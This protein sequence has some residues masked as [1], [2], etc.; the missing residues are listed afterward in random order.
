MVSLDLIRPCS[1][2]PRKDF[3][4]E[5]LEELAE[6]IREQGIVQPL[7][8][9]PAR[10]GEGGFELIAGERRWR[11]ARKL[12]LTE[13]PVIVREAD[14]RSALQLALIENLQRENLNPI[15][16]AM[17]YSELVE[18]FQLTQEDVS[19]KVGKSRTVIANALRLLRLPPDIQNHVREGRLSV[20]HAKVILGLTRSD[21]QCL[22]AKR[23]LRE[24]AN[25]RQT[26][27]WVSQVQ[28]KRG[29]PSSTTAPSFSNQGKT[30]PWSRD[31]HIADLESRLAEKMGT[32]VH[33]R[34]R[35]G[36]G[37]VEIRFFSDE[38]LERVL[39]LLGL[40][41]G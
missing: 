16:E 2:Q 31:S 41:T 25:V 14:D 4:E 38:D 23:I 12:A 27:L 19:S 22:I 20:G 18:R 8:V 36:K 13:V 10:E 9:R 15:E 33:L 34:Y 1:F 35:K 24:G 32:K 39:E 5:A 6:S 3:S 37:S 29:G 40:D 11:A 28:Q 21:E 26:E 17:G 7:I 30:V